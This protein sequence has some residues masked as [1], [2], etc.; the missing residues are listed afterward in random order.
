MS[1]D[2]LC[3]SNKS[4]SQT[5]EYGDELSGI[6]PFQRF[7]PIGCCVMQLYKWQTLDIFAGVANI[8]HVSKYN[9][10]FGQHALMNLQNQ[11]LHTQDDVSRFQPPVT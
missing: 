11:V 1:Y 4:K 10:M 3:E 9:T 8:E 2:G 5:V 6:E 7:Y